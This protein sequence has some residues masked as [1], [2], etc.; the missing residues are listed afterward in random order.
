MKVDVAIE[1][2]KKALEND[3]CVVIG[4]QTTGEARANDA[5]K[6]AGADDNDH[7]AVFDGFISAPKEDLKRI[8]LLLF[9][10]P[11]KPRCVIP[12]EFLFP[13]TPGTEDAGDADD[14]EAVD[15]TPTQEGR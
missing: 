5:A 10:L 7:D 12:P 14:D 3:M 9:P 8:V 4:L 11:P 15:I 1:E 6:K 13:K 2:A